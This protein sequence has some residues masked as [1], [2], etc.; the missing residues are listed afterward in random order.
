MFNHWFAQGAIHG[1][2]TKGEIT[3]LK[4]GSRHVWEGLDAYRPI[5]LLNTELMIL[6]RDL[7]NC[8]QLV[9][10]DL[11]GPEQTFDV[12]GRSIED[13]LHLV[14]E[15]LERM[16]DGTEAALINL[17]QSKAFDWVDHRFLASVLESAGF[18]PEFCRS[19]MNHN[20]W[21][22]FECV[23]DRAVHPEE[24]PSVPSSIWIPSSLWISCLDPSL[25]IPCLDPSLWIPCSEGL[26]MRGEIRTCEV[27]L[28][29]AL[30][31]QGFLR[32]PVISPSLCPTAWT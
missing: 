24:L 13:N 7:T 16:D 18:K 19:M 2:V 30:L 23:R 3:L 5:T 20:P 11:I 22:G 12:K 4:K 29:L 15:V 26:G 8:L 21:E 25:W 10:S 31:Q 9:I 27:S 14:R 1:S 28:L 6:A 32:S 17:D